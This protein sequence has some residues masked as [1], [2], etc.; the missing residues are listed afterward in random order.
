MRSVYA[1]AVLD[2]LVSVSP[3]VRLSPPSA[4]RE[5]V[6]PLTVDQVRALA[7]AIG[8]KYRAM[9]LVQAGLG[10]RI[11]EL[12]ALQLG[13]VDL[14]RRAVRVERQAE[15]R[16]LA[17]V[18][19]KATRSRRTIPLPEVVGEGLAEHLRQYPAM[20]SGLLFHTR[21]DRPHAHNHYGSRVFARAVTVAGLPNRPAPTICGTTTRVCSCSPARASWLS[22]SAWDTRTRRSSCR[23]TGT[24]CRTPRS[25]LARP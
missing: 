21:N 4:D 20:E 15:P 11:G 25:A 1:A 5:R 3:M 24:S 2:R 14:L 8:G 12:L 7:D 10:L 13:D 6:V 16:S 19:P 18:P 9:V 17:M 22:P 23:P